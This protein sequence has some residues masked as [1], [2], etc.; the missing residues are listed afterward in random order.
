MSHPLLS[1]HGDLKQG[2]AACVQSKHIPTYTAPVSVHFRLLFGTPLHHPAQ[3]S[4]SRRVVHHAF[5]AR[6]DSLC[7]LPP[8]KPPLIVLGTVVQ[9]FSSLPCGLCSTLPWH[10]M[11]AAPC[12]VPL[13]SCSA[14]SDSVL[15]LCDAC[16][17]W[18]SSAGLCRRHV[19]S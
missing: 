18:T 13:P 8:L 16:G 15:V 11:V 3:A 10:S 5:A 6:P 17:D 14:S 7:E 19:H 4:V 9:I 1:V 2:L 12:H